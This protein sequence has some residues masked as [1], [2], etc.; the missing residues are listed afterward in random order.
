MTIMCQ[1][2]NGIKKACPAAHLEVIILASGSG[3]VP[4]RLVIARS[5]SDEAI[6][7]SSG[8]S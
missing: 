4:D 5:I 3:L 6:S 7:H 8:V 2:S 1:V